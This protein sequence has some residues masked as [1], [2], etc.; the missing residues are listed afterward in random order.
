MYAHVYGVDRH[1][2]LC[3]CLLQAGQTQISSDTEVIRC[4]AGS[5]S[6]RLIGSG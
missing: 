1:M 2:L 6:T 3:L 5:M 4:Y